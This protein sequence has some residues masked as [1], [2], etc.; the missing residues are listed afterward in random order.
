ME[1]TQTTSPENETADQ[2]DIRLNKDVAAFSYVWI[3]SV[4]VFASRRD[5]PY[6]QY[7]AKQACILF[8]LSIPVA[9]IPFFGRYLVFLVLAGMLLGFINAANGRREE[10]PFVGK[11]ATGEMKPKDIWNQAKPYID[12][13]MHIFGQIFKK[14]EHADKKKDAPAA[15]A[16]PAP[17]Q[18][19]PAQPA[20]PAAPVIGMPEPPAAPPASPLDNSAPKP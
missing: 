8:I 20:A 3:M 16:K 18:A 12:K 13:L 10:L 14:P 1:A 5:S 9:M 2:R 4:I 17:A 11:L 6:I 19:S 7:H 15:D